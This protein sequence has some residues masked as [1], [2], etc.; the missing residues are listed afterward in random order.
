MEFLIFLALFLCTFAQSDEQLS[1][2]NPSLEEVEQETEK[3][4]EEIRSKLYAEQREL[5]DWMPRQVKQYTFFL[6]EENWKIN[7]RVPSM[8]ILHQNISLFASFILEEYL[9][10]RKGRFLKKLHFMR[11]IVGDKLGW[12]LKQF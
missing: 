6:K 5:Y 10:T 2:K 7:F 12:P 9:N 8:V 3:L 1:L 4:T 11:S